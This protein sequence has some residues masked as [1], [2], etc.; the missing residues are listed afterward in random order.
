MGVSVDGPDVFVRYRAVD[1]GL[2]VAHL[3]DRIGALVGPDQVFRDSDSLV[4]GGRGRQ[5]SSRP[6]GPR[7]CHVR[8][9]VAK[10]HSLAEAWYWLR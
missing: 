10:L 5:P 7:A 6:W 1:G 2:A 4:P 3:A 9:L 8:A